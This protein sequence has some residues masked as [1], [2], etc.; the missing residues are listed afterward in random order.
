MITAICLNT[1]VCT[2]IAVGAF[3]IY[4][5]VCFI[6]DSIVELRWNYKYKHRFDKKPIAKCYCI[7]CKYHGVNND[8][9][10]CQLHGKHFPNDWFCKDAK[11][12]SAK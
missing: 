9:S 7:D 2:L 11:P 6:R 12:K 8:N 5:I 10:F 3:V 4:S 1:G